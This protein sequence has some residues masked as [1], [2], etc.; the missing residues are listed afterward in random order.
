MVQEGEK[1]GD[2]QGVLSPGIP[3]ITPPALQVHMALGV[4]RVCKR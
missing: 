3:A 4:A 1:E 2:Y